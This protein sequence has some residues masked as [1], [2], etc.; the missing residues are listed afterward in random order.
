MTQLTYFDGETLR[1]AVTREPVKILKPDMCG[2][3]SD[4]TWSDGFRQGVSAAIAIIEERERRVH[5]GAGGALQPDRTI[6]E[7][8]GKLLA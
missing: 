5:H 6:A 8:K 7:I 4:H 3:L 2:S 1:D